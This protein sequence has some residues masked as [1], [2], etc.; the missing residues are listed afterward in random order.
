MNSLSQLNQELEP[1]FKLEILSK[2]PEN[3][4][5]DFPRII[6]LDLGVIPLK[7]VF[8]RKY[9]T[10]SAGAPVEIIFKNRG[11][12]PH[13][14]LICEPGS[15]ELVAKAAERMGSQPDALEKDYVPEMNEVLFSTKLISSQES[16]KLQF[17]APQTPGRYPFVCTFPGHWQ[18]MNGILEV[19]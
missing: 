10:V 18:T 9:L 17:F 11:I 15:L 14:L 1:I 3:G 13:N 4:I 19:E 16:V 7:M 8:D 6:S 12:Q 2:N 5:G